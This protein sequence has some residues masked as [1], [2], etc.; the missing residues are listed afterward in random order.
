MSATPH[1]EAG[2]KEKG[3]K[4][5]GAGGSGGGRDGRSL[6]LKT[7]LSPPPSPFRAPRTTSSSRNGMCR[8]LIDA[9]FD[10][11]STLKMVMAMM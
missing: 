1:D 10:W 11:A 5:N 9:F 2:W 8:G 6:P 3:E 4:G 7:P